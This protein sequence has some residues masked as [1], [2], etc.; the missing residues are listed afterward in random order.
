MD[1][2]KSEEESVFVGAGGGNKEKLQALEIVEAARSEAS[3]HPSFAGQLFMGQFDPKLLFPFPEEPQGDRKEAEELI[4]KLM[5]YLQENLDPEEVDATRTIPR[6]VIDEMGKMGIFALKVPKEYGGLGFSQANY[7]RLVMRVSSYCGGTGVLISAHQSIGV[8]Q[9]VKLYGTE[10][11]KKKYLPLFRQ[12]KISAFA[13]TEPEVGSD[14]A[15]MSSE[16]KLSDDGSHYILNGIKLWCTNGVIADIIVVMARTAPKVVQ[17]K[18]KKQISAFILDMKTPGIEVV[19]RCEFM[20]LGGIYNGL[21][22]FT[23]VKIPKENLLWAEGRGLALALGTINV[24]RLTLPAG[25]TGGAKQCLSIARR[26][27]KERVQWGMPI[28]LHEAGREKIAYI[29]ATTFAMEA[30][31]WL[32]SFW[33]DLGTFDIRIEAAMAKLFASESLWKIADMTMQ[34]RGGRGYEKGRSLKARGEI[35]Y[36]VER[37]LRDSRVNTIL[38]GSTEIMKLFLA[39]EA[40]DPHL[41]NIAPLLSKKTSVKEKAKAF[42]KASGFYSLWYLKQKFGVIGGGSFSEL[43][44]LAKYYRFIETKSHLMATALFEAMVKYQQKLELRQLLL[45]R[46]IDIG[47][48]L[49]AMAATCSFAQAKVKETKEDSPLALADYFCSLAERRIEANFAA[50]KDNDD[51]KTDKLAEQVINKD[52]RW[53]EEGIQWMGPDV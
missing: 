32:T 1:T 23:N 35:P 27:S 52:F 10:E 20:G 12:G 5:K 42:F 47:T 2:Q 4:E 19:H 11:Q 34:L 31:T 30:V 53:L 24:G 46:I 49:F 16:A 43:G 28:G 38:E 6:K 41:K 3:K 26:W 39:R 8:P 17:G 21:I 18:E 40:M 44:P 14:P 13:L 36:P 9:P 37:I 45:G 22:K 29:A 48:D 51:K 7:N 25:C 50:L 33:A 15:Q